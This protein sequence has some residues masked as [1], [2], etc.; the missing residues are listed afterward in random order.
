MVN[1][2]LNSFSSSQH[3]ETNDFRE[4]IRRRRIEREKRAANIRGKEKR[5]LERMNHL[6]DLSLDGSMILKQIL[7]NVGCAW[8]EFVCFRMWASVEAA[9]NFW[10][11][12]N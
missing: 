5:K 6:D 10:F 7:N 4:I 11:L 3:A 12:Q 2:C 8:S 9:I 1:T